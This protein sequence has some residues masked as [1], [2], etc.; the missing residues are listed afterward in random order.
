MQAWLRVVLGYHTVPQ[1]VVGYLLGSSSALVWAHLG[2]PHTLASIAASPVASG[3]LYALTG[4]AV[5][6]FA[7]KNVRSWFKHRKAKA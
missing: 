6:L 4:L 3:G 5:V 1:V 7:Y 2:S